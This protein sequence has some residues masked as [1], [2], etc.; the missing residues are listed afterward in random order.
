MGWARVVVATATSTLFAVAWALVAAVACPYLADV[1]GMRDVC[2]PHVVVGVLARL[3]PTPVW[4]NDRAGVPTCALGTLKAG[5]A[6]GLVCS[7]SDRLHER[8]S[9]AL[10]AFCHGEPNWLLY[11]D[12]CEL[13]VNS[14][15]L[16]IYNT[17]THMMQVA[18]ADGAVFHPSH[19][20]EVYLPT[21]GAI[22]G[23]MRAMLR[24]PPA[25][26][27][28]AVVGA[29]CLHPKLVALFAHRLWA[30]WMGAALV[31]PLASSETTPTLERLL[32]REL[33]WRRACVLVS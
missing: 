15:W 1:A 27:E 18:T 23:V 20:I 33:A 7:Y 21:P 2:P 26:D 28:L 16:A 8:G 14:E 29:S 13:I 9:A 32:Q 31:R 24:K 19:S 22:P 12:Y 25:S 10:R 4:L 6:T 30:Q 5:N 11:P 17:S 3:V